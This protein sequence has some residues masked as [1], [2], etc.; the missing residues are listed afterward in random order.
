[1]GAEMPKYKIVLTR[2]AKDDIAGIGDYIAYTLLEPGTAEQFV[3]G[4]RN[5]I[6]GLKEFP[7]L[8]Q[9]I[10]DVVLSS[11][12]IRCMPYKNYFVFYEVIDTVNTV[13]VLRIGYNRRNWKRILIEQN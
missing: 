11:Q 12:N 2:K 13:I 4:L 3:D 9:F 5:K 1:M 8:Y 10:D 6:A 7:K